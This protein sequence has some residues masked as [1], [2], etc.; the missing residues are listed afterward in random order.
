MILNLQIH[1]PLIPGTILKRKEMGDVT[2]L[3]FLKKIFFIS[4]GVMLSQIREISGIDGSTLQNWT[5][6]GWVANSKLKRY[7]IDQV[8]HIL[9]I[10]MLRDCMQL[11]RITFVIRYINGNV[12]DRSDD[13]IRD[14]LLYDYICRIIE[15][16]L[17]DD[18]AT[19]DM[20]SLRACISDITADYEEQVTGARKRLNQ[21]LEIIIAAYYASLIKRYS[22]SLVDALM[23]MS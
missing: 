4:S 20:G 15:R 12:N 21:A 22:D 8:A 16:L 6:R 17:A 18:E 7:D 9:I 3:E 2:G 10:N 1:D 5:K 11:D 19:Y 23:I 13:I 14:S